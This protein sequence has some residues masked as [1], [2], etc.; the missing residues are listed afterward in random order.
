MA[1]I[2]PHSS[3]PFWEKVVGVIGVVF[4]LGILGFLIYEALQPSTPP[5]ITITV[6][7]ITP[8][9]N[10]YLVEIQAHNLGEETAAAVEVEGTLQPRDDPNAA[11][12][13]TRT[14]TF[15]YVPAQSMRQGG[16]FFQADPNQYVLEVQAKG[17]VEP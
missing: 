15:D 7:S 1:Q 17:F 14:T 9:S 4:L 3:T 13:E 5:D 6:T 10:G 12:I 8:V 2:E 11:P 16:L